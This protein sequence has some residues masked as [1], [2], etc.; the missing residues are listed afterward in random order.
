MG[1]IRLFIK[2]WR[3]GTTLDRRFQ[4]NLKSFWMMAGQAHHDDIRNYSLGSSAAVAPKS[5]NQLI[6]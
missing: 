6:R 2:G 5:A 1:I 3:G 4:K